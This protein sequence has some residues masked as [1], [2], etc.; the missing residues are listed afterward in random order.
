[1]KKNNKKEDVNIFIKPIF[2]KNGIIKKGVIVRHLALPNNIED[3][4]KI[5]LG[6][7]VENN[8]IEKIKKYDNDIITKIS[9][10]LI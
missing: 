7:P 8:T 3:S 6:L 5:L 10:N 4:K 2:D 1:M 9:K